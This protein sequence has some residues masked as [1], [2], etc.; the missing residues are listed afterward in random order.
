MRFVKSTKHDVATLEASNE[1]KIK[2]FIDAAFGVHEDMKSY[3]GTTITLG[4][5][6]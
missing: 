3:S 5:G 2:C 6:T 4:K 1:Q